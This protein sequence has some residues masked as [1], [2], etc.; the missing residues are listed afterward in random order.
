MKRASKYADEAYGIATSGKRPYV[1]LEEL[2]VAAQEEAELVKGYR[3]AVDTVR[4]LASCG[5]PIEGIL[6]V[7]RN[8]LR[9]IEEK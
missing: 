6:V 2:F 3:A 8:N 4:L 5:T 7:L 1:E 9:A